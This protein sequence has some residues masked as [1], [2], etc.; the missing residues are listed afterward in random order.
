MFHRMK[1][2]DEHGAGPCLVRSTDFNYDTKPDVLWQDDWGLEITEPI[3]ITER[4]AEPL[5]TT[6]RQLFVKD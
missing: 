4:G 2:I 6:P 1:K 5:C 3:L